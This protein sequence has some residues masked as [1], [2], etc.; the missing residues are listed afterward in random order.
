MNFIPG[1]LDVEGGTPLLRHG[2]G[3]A[4]T[5]RLDGLEQDLSALFG[6]QVL[7]GI[8]PE[9]LSLDAG[10]TAVLN[11]VVDVVEPT[12]PDTHVVINV[13]GQLLTARL[14]SRVRAQR[15]DRLALAVDTATISLF[16]PETGLRL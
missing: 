4:E 10:A 15:G 3:G 8:R 7:A 6:R 16:D 5:L 11:G 13:G 12:G 2:E 1:T 14:G 9:A